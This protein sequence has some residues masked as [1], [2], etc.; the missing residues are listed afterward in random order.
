MSRCNGKT[1]RVLLE[2]GGKICYNGLIEFLNPFLDF[3]ERRNGKTH[4]HLLLASKLDIP[5]LVH[6]YKYAKC[7]IDECRHLYGIKN[8]PIFCILNYDDYCRQLSGTRYRQKKFIVDDPI[9]FKESDLDIHSMFITDI[10][11]RYEPE[12]VRDIVLTYLS[13]GTL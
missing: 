5:I 12:E 8:P 4:Y 9:V 11:F 1:L 3:Y 6:S 2:A 13:V 7:L 10:L